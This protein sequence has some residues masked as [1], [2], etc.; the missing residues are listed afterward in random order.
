MRSFLLRTSLVTLLLAAALAGPAQANIPVAGKLS[1]PV[2]V[3]AT[4]LGAGTSTLTAQYTDTTASITAIGTSVSLNVGNQ[5][6]V[7]T[8]VKV[9]LI[10]RTY[11]T[12]CSQ[13]AGDTRGLLS[14]LSVGAPTVSTSVARPGAGQTGYVSYIVAVSMRKANGNYAEIATSWPKAGLGAASIAIPAQG[15]T[16]APSPV[17]EGVQRAGGTSGGINSGDIDSFCEGFQKALPSAPGSGVS[18]TALGTGAPAYY[19]V[20]EPT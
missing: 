14:V 6:H 5:Y 7:D 8:C 12:K 13:N 3:D 17:S 11:S 20:G 1:L 2:K 16:S 19:E 4:G 9:H 15:A 18:T 10:N